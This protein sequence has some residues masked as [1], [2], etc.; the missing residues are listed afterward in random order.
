MKRIWTS[1]HDHNLGQV[2]TVEEL[3][4]FALGVLE[5]IEGEVGMVTGPIGSGGLGSREKNLERFREVIA[6]KYNEG[7]PLFDQMPLQDK[8]KEF[9]DK[10]GGD[11]M[12]ILEGL[13]LPLFKTGKI[14]KFFFIPG[15]ESSL[16]AQWEHDR[17]KEL[18]IEIIY[19][20]EKKSLRN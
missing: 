12:L 1:E 10:S 7:Q 9:Y 19:L 5:K 2:T 18:G 17:A 15:W 16:G 8:I 13:Y 11:K 14:K 3:R 6:Q 20:P 4:D